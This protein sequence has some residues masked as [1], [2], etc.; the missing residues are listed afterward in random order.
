MEKSIKSK[1]DLRVKEV[2]VTKHRE[3][4]ANPNTMHAFNKNYF[5]AKYVFNTGSVIKIVLGESRVEYAQLDTLTPT[6]KENEE[7]KDKAWK[8]FEHV[9][10]CLNN[11]DFAY[12][13]SRSYGVTLYKR[14]SDSPS[15]VGSIGGCSSMN[16]VDFI[17]S[18]APVLS[19]TEGLKST[20]FRY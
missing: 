20:G 5:V 11:P 8:E 12:G 9:T 1:S 15:G 19:P 18:G 7:A 2:I 14:D 13:R 16:V 6:H 10:E 3:G 4:E 17:K